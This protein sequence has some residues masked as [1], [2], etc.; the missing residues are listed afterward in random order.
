MN[1]RP[2]RRRYPGPRKGGPRD[3]DAPEQIRSTFSIPIGVG[4]GLIWGSLLPTGPILGALLGAVVMWGIVKY[5]PALAGRALL[6]ST[7]EPSGR[8]TPRRREYSEAASLAARGRYREA[9][10]AYRAAAVAHP[11]DPEPR[12]RLAALY[13]DHLQDPREAAAWYRAVLEVGPES[14]GQERM[15]RDAIARLGGT[16]APPGGAPPPDR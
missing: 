15:V 2:P 9:A 3:V 1:V 13:R 7:L 11:D 12:L 5:V 4:I 8:S 14:A 16:D 10:A 6:R